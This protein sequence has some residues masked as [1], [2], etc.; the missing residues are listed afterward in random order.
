[1]CHKLLA[2]VAVVVA[3]WAAGDGGGDVIQAG[4]VLQQ[5]YIPGE[6]HTNRTQNSHLNGAF[7]GG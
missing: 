1:V 2:A 4:L 5:G 3:A 6:H 7:C